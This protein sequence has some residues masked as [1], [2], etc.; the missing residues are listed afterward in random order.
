MGKVFT[1]KKVTRSAADQERLD[2]LCR[3]LRVSE[4]YFAAILKCQGVIDTEVGK[5]MESLVWCIHE[6][7]EGE[8]E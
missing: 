4:R 3:V 5:D 2:L 7:L 1:F 6:L 8:K